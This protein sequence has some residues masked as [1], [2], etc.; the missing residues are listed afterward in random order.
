MRTTSVFAVVVVSLLTAAPSMAADAVQGLWKTPDGV[1]AEIAPCEQTS[2]ITLKT[3]RFA[4]RKIGYLKPAN[5]RLEGRITD[6]SDN[7]TYDGHASVTG[8][9]L[10][11]SGCV[12]KVFCRTQVWTRLPP[13]G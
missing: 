1:T 6:P 8:D 4:G 13:H 5:G 11:L 12:M 9:R 3:G 7:K 10:K 2:C